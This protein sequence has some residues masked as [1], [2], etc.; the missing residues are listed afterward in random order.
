MNPTLIQL[1]KNYIKNDMLSNEIM[2]LKSMDDEFVVQ[3]LQ[4]INEL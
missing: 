2:K 3:V 1:K 4:S